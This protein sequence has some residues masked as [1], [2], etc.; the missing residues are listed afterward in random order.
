MQVMELRMYTTLAMEVVEVYTKITSNP[1]I[2]LFRCIYTCTCTVPKQEA[3]FSVGENVMTYIHVLYTWKQF[4]C[5]YVY[6]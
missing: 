3:T 4:M 5:R 2:H 1:C 6:T